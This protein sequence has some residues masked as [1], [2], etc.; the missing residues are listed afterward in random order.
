MNYTT[1]FANL[2]Y[3]VQ[4]G[5]IKATYFWPFSRLSFVSFPT[6]N[7]SPPNKDFYEY[8]TAIELFSSTNTCEMISILKSFL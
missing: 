5:I 2:F 6:E 3:R 1:S 7:D 8:K 4:H